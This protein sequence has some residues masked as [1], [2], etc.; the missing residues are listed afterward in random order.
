MRKLKLSSAHAL[1]DTEKIN[2][3]W[4][5][6]TLI[7]HTGWQS[8]CISENYGPPP[9]YFGAMCTITRLIKNLC[10]LMHLCVYSAA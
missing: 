7:T 1:N 2:T 9:P 3:D 8:R 10:L 4:Y 6:N 5:I